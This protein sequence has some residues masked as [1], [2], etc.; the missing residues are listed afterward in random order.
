MIIFNAIFMKDTRDNIVYEYKYNF[1]RR[2]QELEEKWCPQMSM[3]F[4]P[5]CTWAVVALIT[6]FISKL[7]V[8]LC[9]GGVQAAVPNF[10]TFF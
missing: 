5:P 2:S 7:S 1:E 6:A 10:S 8:M 9:A 3:C 4:E